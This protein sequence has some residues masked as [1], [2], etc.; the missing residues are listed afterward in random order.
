MK[1]Y[2]SHDGHPMLDVSF[3]KLGRMLR[4]KVG[5]NPTHA[6]RLGIRVARL[7]VAGQVLLARTVLAVAG[8]PANYPPGPLAWSKAER[9]AIIGAC[10]YANRQWLS[11][12]DPATFGAAVA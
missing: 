10:A 2:P 5:Q 7:I 11:G 3:A 8:Y 4:A 1:T 6:K 12:L 9:R